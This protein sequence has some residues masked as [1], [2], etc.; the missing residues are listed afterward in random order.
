[1]PGIA[2]SAV[3]HGVQ[4]APTTALVLGRNLF[5]LY[6]HAKHGAALAREFQDGIP[7]NEPESRCVGHV[8]RA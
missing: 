4:V 3:R 6:L 5:G 7:R 1:M 2:A 8:V